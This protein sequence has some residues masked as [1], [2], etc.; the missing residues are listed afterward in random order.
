MPFAGVALSPSGRLPES[1]SRQMRSL[2]CA[3][4]SSMTGTVTDIVI[5]TL[6]LAGRPEPEETTPA[7]VDDWASFS[8]LWKLDD[9]GID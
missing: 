1:R 5:A 3:W 7:S 6:R 4:L 9:L 2:G 8:L